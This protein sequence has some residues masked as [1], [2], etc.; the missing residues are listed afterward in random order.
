MPD[1]IFLVSSAGCSAIVTVINR[2]STLMNSTLKQDVLRFRH[3]LQ[4]RLDTCFLLQIHKDKQI[5]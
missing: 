4:W 1:P 3:V 5:H 2:D